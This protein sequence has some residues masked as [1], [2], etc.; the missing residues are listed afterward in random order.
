MNQ[1]IQ[2]M[3]GGT[4]ETSY[5]FNSSVQKKAFYK[6]KPK[7][8]EAELDIFSKFCTCSTTMTGKSMPIGIADLGC[9]SGPNTLFS[10]LLNIIYKK[11]CEFDIV[12]PEI[13]MYFND[14]PGNDFNTL[15]KYLESFCDELKRNKGDGFG[16]CFDAGIPGTFYGRLVPRDTLHF[17]HSSYSLQWFSQLPRE[18]ENNNQGNIYIST[19]SPPSIIEAYLKQFKSDFTNFLKYRSEELV[20]GGRMVLTLL[21]R[22]SEEC[23]Y[24]WDILALALKDMVLEG[25]IEEQKLISFNIPLYMT[26]SEE[27]SLVIQCEGSFKIDQ[28]EV[29]QVNWDGSEDESSKIDSYNAANCIRAVSE[30]LLM[31]HFGIGE[32]IIDKLFRRYMAIVDNVPKEKAK[33]TNIVISLTK[34]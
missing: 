31:S 15:F 13:V 18:I 34:V 2:N 30:S 33:Y 21:G 4:G 22:T 28:I 14:L 32:E 7:I 24:F 25:M 20:K 26:S 10:Y 23:C 17:V 29:F 12:S 6:T 19:S 9:S 3:N 27:V 11:C 5:A 1:V 16:Q 8:E